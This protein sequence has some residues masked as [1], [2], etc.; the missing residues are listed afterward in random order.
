MRCRRTRRWRDAPTLSTQPLGEKARHAEFTPPLPP[1]RF[2]S[3]EFLAG[4]AI[5]HF[6]PVPTARLG[7]GVKNI[8]RARTLAV[9]DSHGRAFS[10]APFA[11]PAAGR[12]AAMQALALPPS[13]LICKERWA[14]DGRSSSSLSP[15]LTPPHAAGKPMSGKKAAFQETHL[16][17]IAAV[18]GD[19]FNSLNGG[20]E[21]RHCVCRL[22]P[23]GWA[24]RCG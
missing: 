16:R 19:I 6:L 20:E 14:T 9:K 23:A 4:L 10:C 11:L 5:W 22:D 12:G 7:N 21:R 2:A 1:R 18:L 15:F 3:P 13:H 24:H 8:L 17:T